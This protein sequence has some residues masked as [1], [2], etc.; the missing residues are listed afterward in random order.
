MDTLVQVFL[1]VIA[2]SALLQALFVAGLAIGMGKAADQVDAFADDY[3]NK[4]LPLTTKLGTLAHGLADASDTAVGQ[5]RRVELRISSL[6]DQIGRA[7]EGA[8]DRVEET[9]S[10]GAD[11]I[12]EHLMPLPR[13]QVSKAGAIWRGLRTGLRVLRG[14]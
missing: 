8:A 9:V 2:L 5:A 6:A 14:S 13:R 4:L 10:D 1:A 12:E 11:A 7:V 3:D